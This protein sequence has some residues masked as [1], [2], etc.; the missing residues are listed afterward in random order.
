MENKHTTNASEEEKSSQDRKEF[1]MHMY[2]QMFND[3]NRHILVVWQ[4]VGVL[5]G[6][7]ALFG[8]AERA[9]LP[10]DVAAALIV[11]IG[12]WLLVHL[13]DAGYWYNR[14]LAIIA[15]IERQF[16]KKEDL[17]NIHYYFGKHRKENIM[18]TH[19]RIQYLFGIGIISLVL[20]YHFLKR[21]APGF[22]APW[23][24]FEPIRCLPYLISVGGLCVVLYFHYKMKKKYSEFIENSPGIDVDTKG[25]RYGEGHPI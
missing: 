6:A 7:F 23:S 1:L 4:S 3:I 14:N 15:N 8:L 18:L 11:L 9:V 2:D 5:I 10:L 22:G 25:I 16:L 19:L 21:V 24:N 13:E 20:F 12:L 17:R